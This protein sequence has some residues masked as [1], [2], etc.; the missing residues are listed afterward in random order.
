M[1]RR[2]ANR[3]SCA[4]QK[5]PEDTQNQPPQH[6]G[7]KDTPNTKSLDTQTPKNLK[8]ETLQPDDS[9]HP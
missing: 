2:Y 7:G 8:A 4:I 5:S 1:E 6:W 3:F 9:K